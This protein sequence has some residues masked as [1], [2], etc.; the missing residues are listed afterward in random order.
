MPRVRFTADFDWKPKP[1]VTQAYR[2][3]FEGMVTTP[4]AEAAVKAGRAVRSPAKRKA[5]ANG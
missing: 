5:K 4:C 1:Q 3:G 2:E